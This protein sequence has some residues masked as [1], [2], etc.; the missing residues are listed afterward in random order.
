M[1]FGFLL[2]LVLGFLLFRLTVS[3]NGEKMANNMNNLGLISPLNF[4]VALKA[5]LAF[6]IILMMTTIATKTVGTMGVIGSS[7][8]GGLVSAEAV[9]FT[10]FSLASANTIS[11]STATMCALCTTLTAIL[12]KLIFTKIAGADKKFIRSVLWRVIIMILPA[13]VVILL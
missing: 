2:P 11:I 6:A 8:V 9:I 10:T 5:L 12:N 7:I 1:L 3:K 13:L 4:K